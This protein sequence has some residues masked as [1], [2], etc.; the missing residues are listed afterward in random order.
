MDIP[1]NRTTTWPFTDQGKT[2]PINIPQVGPQTLEEILEDFPYLPPQSSLLGLGLDGGPIFLDLLN[3]APQALLIA[4][5]SGCGK[6]ALLKSMLRSAMLMNNSHEVQAVILA[7][8][9]ADWMDVTAQF[10]KDYFLAIESVYDRKAGDLVM[11]MAARAEQRQFGRELGA[12]I[13]LIV[14]SLLD[15]FK[16]DYD[17]TLNFEW[18]LSNGAQSQ[19]WPIASVESQHATLL[20]EWIH[21]FRTR[22]LGST[23]DIGTARQLTGSPNPP[24]LAQELQFAV[25]IGQQWQPFWIPL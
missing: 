6:T 22:I 11:D 3:P 5:Q 24:R 15:I 9:P 16:Q 21:R 2:T 23:P 4:G 8:N 17:A 18:L 14:E 25:R 1:L 19:V 12:P 20:S 13:M 10:P 7:K